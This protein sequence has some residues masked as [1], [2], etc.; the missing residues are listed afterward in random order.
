MAHVSRNN[1]A[2]VRDLP[3]RAGQDPSMLTTSEFADEY[4]D[5]LSGSQPVRRAGW[6]ELSLGEM[7]HQVP[8]CVVPE[9]R[10]ADVI[11]Q[12]NRAHA[13]AALVLENDHVLGIFTERDVLTRVLEA[14]AGLERP[15]SDLMTRS[16][17]VLTEATLLS[18]ALRTLALGSYHHLPVVD[19]AGYPVA[20]VSL[21]S[22]IAFLADQFPNEIMNA[23]PE[24]LAYPPTVDG[25]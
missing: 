21:Q 20:L 14:G 18:V 17:H 5:W 12:M 15:V 3:D 1:P 7:E 10:V 23:P 22:I 13:S 4:G 24:H 19:E 16:P 9:A 25:G 2:K 11:A 6:L 8:L